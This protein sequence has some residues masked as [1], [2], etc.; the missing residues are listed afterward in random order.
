M[1]RDRLRK[2]D[3]RATFSGIGTDDDVG[4]TRNRRLAIPNHYL[5][6]A[7]FFDLGV[8][9]FADAR[10]DVC[11]KRK[12]CTRGGNAF[13]AR[14]RTIRSHRAGKLYHS[15]ALAGIGTDDDVGWARKSA[16]HD[17][18]PENMMRL[19]HPVSRRACHKERV[20]IC[21]DA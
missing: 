5:K 19:A 2:S 10:D 14:A 3:H 1:A 17:D 8:E 11:P 12:E 4:W 16:R 20:S 15:P 13:D 9:I 7:T 6:T 21:R 18:I